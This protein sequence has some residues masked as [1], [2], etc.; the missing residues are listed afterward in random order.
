MSTPRGQGSLFAD[1][2]TPSHRWTR[3]DRT[4]AGILVVESSRDVRA[5]RRVV[6]FIGQPGIRRAT[7]LYSVWLARSYIG[8]VCEG[9]MPDIVK[10]SSLGTRIYRLLVDGSVAGWF[11]T[12]PDGKLAAVIIQQGCSWFNVS[13]SRRIFAINIHHNFASIHHPH[14]AWN[15]SSDDYI[16]DKEIEYKFPGRKENR[17]SSTLPDEFCHANTLRNVD[18]RWRKLYRYKTEFFL[19]ASTSRRY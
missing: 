3:I 19:R 7:R 14:K 13:T 18:H 17:R 15:Q 8:E 5:D 11:D 16:N 10:R 1:V 12:A 9:L 6:R 4:H 2:Y